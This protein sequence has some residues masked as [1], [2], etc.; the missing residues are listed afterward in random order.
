MRKGHTRRLWS[1]W[2]L[3]TEWGIN[4][5]NTLCHLVDRSCRAG[6]SDEDSI[7]KATMALFMMEF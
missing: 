3:I 2:V 5:G 6:L 1:K 4:G 7:H